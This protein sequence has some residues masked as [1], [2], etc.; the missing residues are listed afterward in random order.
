[1]ALHKVEGDAQKKLHRIVPAT[2]VESGWR[3]RQDLQPILRDNPEALDLGLYIIGE[4]V[5]SWEDSNRRIDLLGLDR[6]ANLV[7]IELKRGGEGEHMELQALRYAA[8]VSAM[9]LDAVV[10]EHE[11]YLEKRGQDMSE[12]R[13]RILT[14]LEE[15]DDADVVIGSVPRII[16]VAPSF[17]REIT[18]T[19]L[20]LNSQGLTIRCI[21]AQPYNLGDDLYLDIEQVIPLQEASDYQVRLRDKSIKAERKESKDK[22]N[23]VRTI[24][25]LVAR[26]LLKEGTRLRLFRMPRNNLVIDNDEARTAIFIGN[27]EGGKLNQVKWGL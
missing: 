21:K 27:S 8:M 9:D 25:V 13:R 12:A 14:F 3:E 18:T 26:K 23:Q 4:E 7:I 6:D 16:L 15:Q 17:S 22:K 5:S 1:M 24:D 2:F 11:T 20:W 10:R 19:V